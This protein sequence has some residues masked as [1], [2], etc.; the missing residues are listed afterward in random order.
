M[1]LRQRLGGAVGLLEND[2]RK[3][4]TSAGKR[5]TIGIEERADLRK[6][7]KHDVQSWQ[8]AHEKGS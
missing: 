7:R 1:T 6:R 5:Q 2:A 3:T 8:R 4:T